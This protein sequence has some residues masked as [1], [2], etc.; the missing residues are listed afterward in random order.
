MADKCGPLVHLWGIDV[1][2]Q[3]PP[4][5]ATAEELTPLL[6]AMFTEAVPF[7]ETLPAAAERGDGSS[8]WKAKGSKTFSRSAAPVELYERTVSAAPLAAA[9]EDHKP[10]G[11]DAKHVGSEMWAARRSVHENAAAAGTASWTEWTRCFKD[12]HAEAE[13]EFTATVVSTTRHRQWDLAGLELAIAGTTWTDWTLKYEESVHKLP[14]PLRRRVFPPGRRAATA[15]PAACSLAMVQRQRSVPPESLAGRGQ[16]DSSFSDVLVVKQQP[17]TSLPAS[18]GTTPSGQQQPAAKDSRVLARA[19]A[20]ARMTV[21]L[22]L[23][24]VG[25]QAERLERELKE[26]VMRTGQDKEFRKAHE[27]RL[28]DAWREIVAVKA[29][30]ESVRGR[31][32]DIQ[33]DFERCQRETA[34]LRQLLRREVS[35]LRDLID[36]MA[37]QLDSLPTAAD[38]DEECLL[39]NAQENCT[40]ETVPSGKRIIAQAPASTRGRKNCASR[41]LGRRIQEAISSTRRWHRDHK[42]TALPDAEF[43]ANYLKQQ[44][45]RD[46]AM[47]VL[48]QKAIQKRLQYGRRPRASSRPRSLDE[49]CR[50]V[51]WND[52]IETVEVVLIKDKDVAERMLS[53]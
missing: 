52:V 31:Q 28:T 4:A 26:L 35:G 53:K 29:Q 45:K 30:M 44:S 12:E 25:A 42:S 41:P 47:A 21:E 20:L 9:V 5:S 27:E 40:G 32:D 43:I 33:T 14:A 11:I 8:P 18:A 19:D 22:N 36:S 46:P 23:R 37:S 49:F 17:T 2:S 39:R 48:I 3:L 50:D 7:I 6:K 13:K 34:E 24:T 15:D 51:T 16:K 38:M 10:P 1:A